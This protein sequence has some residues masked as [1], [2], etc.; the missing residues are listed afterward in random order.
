MDT[1]LKLQVVENA[2]EHKLSSSAIDQNSEQ[3]K[4]KNFELYLINEEKR[5]IE[6]ERKLIQ[7]EKDLHYNNDN[8]NIKYKKILIIYTIF[9]YL[10]FYIL[11]TIKI[12]I[13][14]RFLKNNK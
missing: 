11:R 8:L 13:K 2:K 7:K 10:L 9:I 12:F 14:K 1:E 5:L 6:K 3:T 4:L